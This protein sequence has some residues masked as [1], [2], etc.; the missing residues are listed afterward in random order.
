MQCGLM[1]ERFMEC[2]VGIG[3]HSNMV[4]NF[5]IGAALV[6]DNKHTVFTFYNGTWKIV[7]NY[8]FSL[9]LFAL[10]NMDI[11]IW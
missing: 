8:T 3:S 6:F 1:V 2:F 7:S 5:C 11:F 4:N 10:L 9:L